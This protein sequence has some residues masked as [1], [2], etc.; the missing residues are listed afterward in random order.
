MSVE[1][2][3]FLVRRYPEAIEE[4]DHHGETPLTLARYNEELKSW[5]ESYW[6]IRWVRVGDYILLRT[7][8]DQK[9]ASLKL[10][11]SLIVG[12]KRKFEAIGECDLLEF[13]FV[14]SPEGIF[15]VI[16]CYL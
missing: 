4:S 9:R 3:L 11:N 15:A 8:V 5:M 6:K 13:V 16:M 2:I 14:T 1:M 10:N 12:K 7:L